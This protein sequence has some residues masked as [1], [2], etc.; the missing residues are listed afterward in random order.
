MTNKLENE[1]F[2]N[3][4]DSL[5]NIKDLKFKNIYL[6][7]LNDK[8]E[9]KEWEIKWSYSLQNNDINWIKTWT[10]LH[11]NIHNPYVK[12]AQ[13]EMLHLNYWSGYKAK[14]RCC[15]CKEVETNNKHIVNEFI[16]L[17][18]IIR[19]FQMHIKFNNKLTITFGI[20]RETLSQFILFHIKT[21]V[22]R[23]RFIP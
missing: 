20:N 15:L 2:L 10:N 13:W 14:E 17:K 4:E 23:S 11:D 21:V 9:I 7:F 8:S 18:D 16:I 12:S 22:F 3:I 6:K 5:Y 19:N 1:Y